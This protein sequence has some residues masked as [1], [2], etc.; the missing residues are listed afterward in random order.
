VSIFKTNDNSSLKDE[1]LINK[2]RFSHDT[3]YL[4]ELF[5]RYVPYV[6]GVALGQLRSQREAE[7]LTMTVFNKIS[8]DLKRI[9]VKDFSSWL[10]SLVKNLCNTE[11]K[12][13]TATEGESKLI[14]MEEL[15]E[16]STDMF[17]NTTEDKNMKIDSNNLRLAINTLNES[18]KVC[19]D[20]FYMQNRSYQ[21]VADITGFS[22]NQVK[23][24]IQNGKRL[25]KTYLDNKSYN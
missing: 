22:I 4:G 14:L 2:Y 16:D 20:L 19:I 10:Y 18:Q 15:S 5:L 8:S 3:S 24:N 7:E 23:T 12:K 9:E 21:E 6:Y 25:L 17:I 11:V 13:K 1:E